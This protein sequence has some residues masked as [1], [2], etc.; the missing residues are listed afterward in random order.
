MIK[1]LG[2][3]VLVEGGRT[4]TKHTLESRPLRVSLGVNT[5]NS[6]KADRGTST[7]RSYAA[8]AF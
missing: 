6:S 7:S 8:E 2:K 1:T 4:F 5:Q 3:R